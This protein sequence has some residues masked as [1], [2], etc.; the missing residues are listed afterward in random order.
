MRQ[1]IQGIVPTD[2]L[3]SGVRLGGVLPS[4]CRRR[5]SGWGERITFEYK[6]YGVQFPCAAVLLLL[7]IATSAGLLWAN[8]RNE[9]FRISEQLVYGALFGKSEFGLILVVPLAL[10]V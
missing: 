4:L 7:C 3:V 1:H 8:Y 5:G 2:H 9:D 10:M 6:L